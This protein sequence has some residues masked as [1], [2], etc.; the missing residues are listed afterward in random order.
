MRVI[1]LNVHSDLTLVQPGRI[2]R[3]TFEFG[4][5]YQPG[6]GH[7]Q[8]YPLGHRVVH[9]L[10]HGEFVIAVRIIRYWSVVEHPV[11]AGHWF[12]VDLATDSQLVVVQLKRRTLNGILYDRLTGEFLGFNVAPQ[13]VQ[14][15]R[16]FGAR[17]RFHVKVF[18]HDLK[19]Q[20]N[21]TRV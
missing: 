18:V 20:K 19:K 5:S 21:K 3:D 14:Q 6:S 2:L 8:I 15:P 13:L 9:A 11:D 4:L 7:G 17:R 1:Y 10:V 16:R 12:A